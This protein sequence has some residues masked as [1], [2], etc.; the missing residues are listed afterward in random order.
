MKQTDYKVDIHKA[1]KKEQCLATQGWVGTPTEH[2]LC[3]NHK[4]FCL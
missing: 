4:A 3:L 2:S 1:N